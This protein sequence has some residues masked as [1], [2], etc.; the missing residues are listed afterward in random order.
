[1]FLL[2]SATLKTYLILVFAYVYLCGC[3]PCVFICAHGRQR[4][5]LDTLEWSDGDESPDVGAAHCTQV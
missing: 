2:P 4:G 3:M 1:M 5:A